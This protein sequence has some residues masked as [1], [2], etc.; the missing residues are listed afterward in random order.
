MTK[1]ANS[2]EQE[3]ARTARRNKLKA[4]RAA[5]FDEA[6]SAVVMAMSCEPWSVQFTLAEKANIARKVIRR[7]A[8]GRPPP[9]CKDALPLSAKAIRLAVRT[10][11]PLL[12]KRPAPA[13]RRRP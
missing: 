7:L 12:A 10:V 6:V 8:S 2:P 1:R 9:P 5:W 13:R 11:E 3:A 4:A